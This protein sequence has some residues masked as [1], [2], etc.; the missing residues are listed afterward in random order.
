MES[1][2]NVGSRV[3]C[4]SAVWA[5]AVTHAEPVCGLEAASGL[6]RCH[7][8][9]RRVSESDRRACV[10]TAVRAVP[11]VCRS[12]PDVPSWSRQQRGDMSPRHVAAAA[13]GLGRNKNTGQKRPSPNKLPTGSPRASISGRW[14]A[15]RGPLSNPSATCR[16]AVLVRDPAG[17]VG[18]TASERPAPGL[19]VAT[20]WFC[21][22]SGRLNRSVS[23][24][25]PYPSVIY[26]AI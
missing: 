1:G 2:F 10:L 7:L 11:H 13:K 3:T 8:W 23:L 15:L 5:N 4:L 22:L 16:G 24:S 6:P 20:S 19:C 26:L 9:F 25:P 17:W 18:E 14:D 21:R 12:G